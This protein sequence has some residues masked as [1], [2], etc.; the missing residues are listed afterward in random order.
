M[1]YWFGYRKLQSKTSKL[2]VEN[3]D[4]LEYIK[5][6]TEYHQLQEKGWK[7]QM[8]SLELAYKE[9]YQDSL[10]RDYEEFKA[11]DANHD[12]IITL[13]EVHSPPPFP[14]PLLIASPVPSCSSLPPPS[15]SL[16][17]PNICNHFL[18]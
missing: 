13:D 1:V 10:E 7:D 9:L 5:L 6:Q 11:P 14:T 16:I 3:S 17:L 12:E 15:L 8:S 4:L 18:N 2:Q